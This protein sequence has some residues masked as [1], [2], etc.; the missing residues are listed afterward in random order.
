[1]AQ[2]NQ[3]VL[4]SAGMAVLARIQALGA[5]LTFDYVEIGDGFLAQGQ[6]L[7]SLTSIR[8]RIM[9]LPITNLENLGNGSVKIRA[10]AISNEHFATGGGYIVPGVNLS[11]GAY[12]RE[13]GLF[14][15]DPDNSS[16]SI[17][18][19]IANA[20]NL[21]DFLPPYN[22]NPVEELI[23]LVI[24]IGTAANVTAL[25]NQS[26][27][28][29]TRSDFDQLIK[30][31]NLKVGNTNSTV[32]IPNGGTVLTLNR[33]F[34]NNASMF[35]SSTGQ[36]KCV[37]AGKYRIGFN[38]Q[39]STSNGTGKRSIQININ[40]LPLGENTLPGMTTGFGQS[41]STSI[42]LNVNDVI[43]VDVFQNSGAAIDLIS[44]REYSPVLCIECFELTQL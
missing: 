19:A 2:F 5:T 1:M 14:V 31:P 8:H 26:M 43:T 37:K 10:L 17:L 12:I 16:H 42:Q 25:M 34:Y 30:L 27:A 28:Y 4:T 38:V 44:N 32:S 9:V 35:N 29:V 6:T 11:L 13:I 20:G 33:I 7:Q 3:L 15:R 18:Y 22:V 40:G 36:I 39:W 23:N 21:A 41:Y 24:S